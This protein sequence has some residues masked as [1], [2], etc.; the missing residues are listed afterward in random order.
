MNINALKAYGIPPIQA[1]KAEPAPVTNE[2]KVGN[3]SA[4]KSFGDMFTE[5]IKEVD[6]LHKTADTKTTAMMSGADGVTPHEAMIA[7]EKADVAFQL[8]NSIRSKIVRAYEDIMR[9]QV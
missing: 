1:P 6:T 7:L 2:P 5:A 8:M 9:T 3:N 4:P